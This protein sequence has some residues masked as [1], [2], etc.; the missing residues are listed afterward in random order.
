MVSI[1]GAIVLVVA[2]LLPSIAL[3]LPPAEPDLNGILIKPIPEK[4]VVLTFDDGCASHATIVAPILKRLGFGATFYIS[5]FGSFHTRKDWYLTWR[6]MKALAADGFEIGNHTKGHAALS[7]HSVEGCTRYVLDMEDQFLANGVPKSTTFCWPMYAVNKDFFQTLASNGYTFAR[8]GHCR[9]YRPTVDSPFD[10]PSFSISN[11]DRIETFIGYVR[12]ATGGRVVVLT[13]HGVPDIEHPWVNLDPAR[14]EEMMQYLKDNGYKTIAM[15]D[16]AGYVDVAK[17]A[18][19]PPTARTVKEPGPPPTVQN[20]KPYPTSEIRT[21]RFPGLPPARISGSEIS[22]TAPHGADVTALAP[23]FDLTPLATA[24]PASKVAQDFTRP[25]TYTVKTSK[26]RTRTYTVNVRKAAADPARKPT[27]RT[28]SGHVK[29]PITLNSGTIL[30]FSRVHGTAPLVLDSGSLAVGNGFGS[31]WDGPVELKGNTEISAYNCIAFN[32]KSGGISGPGGF[33]HTGGMV[34]LC[35]DNDYT[36]R[37]IVKKGILHVTQSLYDND[38]AS[39]TPANITV[40]IAAEL[41]LSVGS[42]GEFS[43][44]QAGAMLTNLTKV[45]DRNG[46]MAGAVFALDASNAKAAV[47][48]SDT[49]AN[50]AGPGGGA[51]VLKKCGAG[52]LRLSGKNTYTGRTILESGSLSISALNCIVGGKPSSSLGAPIDAES[53]EIVIGRGDG[54]CALI[55]TGTG[56]TTDRVI[57]LA[58]KK[59]TVTFDQSGTGLLKFTSTFAISGYGASKTVLLKGDTAGS[60]EIAGNIVNPYDRAS[61][62]TTAVTKSGSGTWTLSG[63]N[64]Y[65]GPTLVTG[66][67]LSIANERSLGS[68]TDVTIDTGATLE[69]NFQ[70]QM[71]VGKLTLNGKRQPAGAYSATNAPAFIKG[72]GILIVRQ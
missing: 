15:R 37:T 32:D 30:H 2:I 7:S 55:Y 45:V 57:N 23:T 10:V 39:W 68:N 42:A 70:G 44:S 13:L 46:L 4:L 29:D 51:F 31:T 27:E 72:T 20:D 58:G 53:G 14:F 3:A 50:S 59:S 40:G 1:T 26:G 62:A 22:V 11:S 6:Q 38:P 61:K 56:E 64:S 17:A 63:S 43:A 34:K 21:F 49:I 33:T 16:L 54:E 69:L 19:L 60:G 48:I 8:G 47:V 5:D 9:A 12:Q 18:K 67:T 66:G 65:T 25:R 35:G 71:R 52:M 41:R 24:E 28:L 36:G